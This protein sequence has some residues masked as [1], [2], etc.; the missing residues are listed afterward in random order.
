MYDEAGYCESTNICDMFL[1]KY[2]D[3]NHCNYNVETEN[4]EIIF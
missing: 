1:F 4:E 3:Y 2:C